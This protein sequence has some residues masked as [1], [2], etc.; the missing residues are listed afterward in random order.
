M[1]ITHDVATRN[2][3]ADQVDA[4]IGAA[5]KLVLL[6]GA[7]EVATMPLNNPAFGAASGG[8]ITM[9]VAP[10]PTDSAATGGTVTLFELQETGGTGIVLGAV[11]D[12]TLSKNPINALDVVTITSFTYT[13]SV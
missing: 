11:A 2:A 6:A 8:V 13:A 12:I 3:F 10:V 9:D 4:D 1:A 5:G 7:V